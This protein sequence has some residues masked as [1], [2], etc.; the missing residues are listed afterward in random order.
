MKTLAPFNSHLQVYM[1][2]LR[3]L[4][5]SENQECSVIQCI[6]MLWI[7]KQEYF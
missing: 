7:L 6:R 3:V 2:M 1:Y 5:P 4:K